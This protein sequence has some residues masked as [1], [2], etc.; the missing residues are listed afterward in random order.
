M[1]MEYR[2]NA[3][4][5]SKEIYD[6]FLTEENP[7]TSRWI[8]IPFSVE[9]YCS[10]QYLVISANMG[11]LYPIEDYL[12]KHGEPT[13]VIEVIDMVVRAYYHVIGYLSYLADI[14][15]FVY[16]VQDQEHQYDGNSRVYLLQVPSDSNS[17]K[18]KLLHNVVDSNNITEQDIIT[19]LFQC[20]YNKRIEITELIKSEFVNIAN[21]VLNNMK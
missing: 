11:V 17:E 10:E 15:S 16:Y 8:A 1:S 19:V 20:V 21:A 6:N 14:K 9:N 7:D 5:V 13:Q 12:G 4:V 2:L 18:Y 3:L